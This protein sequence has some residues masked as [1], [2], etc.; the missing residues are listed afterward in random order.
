MWARVGGPARLK[1]ARAPPFPR[2]MSAESCPVVVV[3]D[4]VAIRGF[5]SHV[6]RSRGITVLEAATA[7]VGL[8]VL[9]TLD[10]G[11]TPVILS[12]K[13]LPG[14]NGLDLIERAA[15]VVEDFEV[16]LMTAFADHEAL[17]RSVELGVFRCITKPFHTDDLVAAVAAAQAVLVA[18]RAVRREARSLEARNAELERRLRERSKRPAARAP[19]R[20]ALPQGLRIL[21]VDDDTLVQR[22]YSRLFPRQ[23]VRLATS[24]EAALETILSE[25]PDIVVCDLHM[26]EMD[27]FTFYEKLAAID[28]RL[29]ARVVFV[30]SDDEPPARASSLTPQ[31]P[32]V[33]KPFQA[34]ELEGTV[35]QLLA[36]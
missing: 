5:A 19:R 2:S 16:I 14:M 12:D 22:A 24:P 11:V 34:S 8:V 30:S 13:C 32:L 3:E 31:V 1:V 35:L 10:R 29:A 4:D 33:R 23:C 9:G 7:E 18:R 28:P 25:P 15:S 36:S 21:F 17:M 27:G 26:H 20:G 6:L